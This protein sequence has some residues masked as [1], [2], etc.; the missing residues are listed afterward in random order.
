V[1][2]GLASLISNS[3]GCRPQ[4]TNEA[5]SSLHLTNRDIQIVELV[6]QLRALIDHQIQTALFSARAASR[7][8]RRLTLLVRHHYL[9]RLPRRRA[10]DPAIYRLTRRSTAGNRLLR[11]RFGDS[12]IK[13]QSRRLGSI[14]HLLGVNELRVRAIRACRDLGWKLCLWQEPEELAPLLRSVHLI[15][16][17]YF[18]IQRQVSGQERTSAFFIELE[19]SGKSSQ[20]VVSKLRRYGELYYGGRYQELFGTRAL[21][22]LFVFVSEQ[23]STTSRRVDLGVREASRRGISIARFSEMT[24]IKG[25][26]PIELLTSPIWREPNRDPA[27]VLFS[28]DSPDPTVRS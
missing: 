16:D 19:R 1:Q 6:S 9:D 23:G 11:A 22:V 17:G 24:T 12:A 28:I 5:T 4:K 25:V 14:G 13:V 20:V 3:L 26:G 27:T 10:T 2:R 15:P 21:R 8:Q 7:C 18:Q